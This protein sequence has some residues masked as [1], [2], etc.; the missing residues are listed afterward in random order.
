M[1]TK[2]QKLGALLL[3]LMFI[4]GVCLIPVS[5]AGETSGSAGDGVTWTFDEKT[6]ALTIAG[7]GAM[8]DYYY[9]ESAGSKPSP[10]FDYSFQIFF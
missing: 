7:S 1:K 8:N 2:L 3:A 4:F 5:A 9:S 10:W 6:G